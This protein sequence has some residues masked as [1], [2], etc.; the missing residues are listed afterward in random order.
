MS[1][2]SNIQENKLQHRVN[3]TQRHPVVDS[4]LPKEKT[5]L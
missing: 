3:G 4:V 5:F 1:E 2:N